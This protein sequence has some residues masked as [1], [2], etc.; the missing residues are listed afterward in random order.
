MKNKSIL[1]L[2]L[3]FLFIFA[4]VVFAT[5]SLDITNVVPDTGYPGETAQF[6]TT[7][8]N[9][10]TSTIALVYLTSTTLTNGAHSISAPIVPAITNLIPG[11]PQ[12][13]EFTLTIPSVPAGIYS[14]TLTAADQGNSTNI[15]TFV[16]TLNVL[17]VRKMSI[18]AE[19]LSMSGQEGE[20]DITSSFNVINSGSQAILPSELSFTFNQDDFKDS[21]DKKVNLAFSFVTTTAINPGETRAVGINA[22]INDN[23]KLGNYD[24]VISLV[25]TTTSTVLDTFELEFRV[26][27]Q[28]CEEGMQ[29]D[30]LSIDIDDPGD[31]DD[32]SP[33]ETIDIDVNVEN[34]G[35]DDLDVVVEAIL[36]NIDKDE[37]IASVES[38]SIEIG[39]GDDED[40]SISLEV[41]SDE[42]LDEDD[43]Y[44]LYIKAYEDGSEDDNCI[45]D[46]LELEL[47][48]NKH[49]V[50]I[51]EVTVTPSTISCGETATVSV[52]I[53]N[54]GSSDEDDVYV[55]LTNSE[56]NLNEVSEE[57]DLDDYSGSDND[58]II[59]F[60]LALPEDAE[61]KTYTITAK[62]YYNND[63]DY[64]TKDFTLTLKDCKATTSKAALTLTQTSIDNVNPGESF[65]IQAKV[66]NLG[67][68]TK[69]FVLDAQAV[70][71]W[72][73]S[74]QETITLDSNEEKTIY[75]TMKANTATE[76]G[77]QNVLL[78]LK[79]G[80]ETIATKTLNVKIVKEGTTT[81]TGTFTP[82]SAFTAFF[83]GET[84]M[85]TIFWVIGDIV[86][87]I[88]AIYF[89]KLIFRRQRTA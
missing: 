72:A 2:T 10:G 16:Y 81:T 24:G 35:S 41:P 47:K 6:T 89:L 52:S 15:D 65:Q 86:L 62:V 40:F 12:T 80:S 85:S 25:D 39:D 4:T 33:G 73:N 75:L 26:Q 37:D 11:T 50:V 14:A 66:R 48:R 17:P 34:E 31:G 36:Y 70:G 9:T 23:M 28:I 22:D 44:V 43:T 51:D 5:G 84:K 58:A 59:K 68:N 74:A 56:L 3:A 38:D 8:S 29:G 18:N 7:V 30:D 42:D 20:D 46:S 67:S 71:N 61:D 13:K 88:I 82:T 78:T 69:T 54:L 55:K 1:S 64:Y 45:E 76:E 19:T 27:P 79:S 53:D 21:K 63:K 83:K 87:V 57:Y 49:E 60:T 32:F 77:S